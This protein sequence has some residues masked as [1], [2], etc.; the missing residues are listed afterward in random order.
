MGF[1]GRGSK[2]GEA[3]ATDLPM[4][5]ADLEALLEDLAAGAKYQQALLPQAA[6]ALPGYDFATYY[7]PARTVSGDFY[8]L[9]SLSGGKLGLVIA[10]ASGKSIPAALVSMMCHLLFRV[11]P[12]PDA[13]PA[14]VL[15]NVNRLLTGNIKRGTF[16]TAIYAWLDPTAHALTIANAGHLPVVVWH[17][18]AKV[19]TTHRPPGPVLGVLSPEVYDGAVQ[20]ETIPLE[21]GDRFVLLTDGVNEAMAPGQ[22]EFGMEHLRRQL[23]ADSD[24][25]SAQFLKGIADMIE[26]HR[27]GGDASDDITIVTG[28]RL[29]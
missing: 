22:R 28:R 25:P 1:F 8:D 2:K 3:E 10:D 27:G 7:R 19:A 4:R 29:A 18:K 15:S 24:G 6:P 11:Q 9:R 21:A 23:K 20:P 13:P 26:L 12:E 5:R 16:V 17:A 14:R